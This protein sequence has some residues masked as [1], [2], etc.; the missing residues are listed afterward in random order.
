M[1]DRDLNGR[2]VAITGAA[3]GIGRA[4]AEACAGAGMRVAIGDL[5]R[6]LSERAAAEVGNAA[7][8]LQVDVR[9][10]DSFAAFLEEAESRLGGL[11]VLVNNAGVLHLGRFQEEEPEET[12][13]QLAVNVAG[14]ITGTRL[15][16]D[17]F[18]PRGDGH[19][20]NIASSA[21]LVGVAGGATYSATKHA[22]VGFTRALRRELHG[23][24][25][26][27]TIVMPG[28]IRTEMI[29]GYAEGRGVRV[30]EPS[31]VGEAIVGALRRGRA[32]VLVPSEL[33]V[34]TRLMQVLPP[35]GAD[36]LQRFMRVDR[37]ML[38]ADRSAHERY[39]RR[40]VEEG[41]QAA[42]R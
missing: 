42:P 7:V 32:E 16:L 38:D 3:R 19:I 4:T 2:A 22:V 23:S 27:T 13:R 31:A 21:G 20:V 10:R 25:V 6:A 18:L 40:F 26:R 39:E 14:V 28:V 33:S 36:A 1:P 12:E 5:D 41:E 34:L 24:G 37:V 9:D 8:G 15:A 30:I 11:D 29:T 17:R 35:R